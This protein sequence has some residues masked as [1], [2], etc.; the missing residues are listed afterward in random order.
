[1]KKKSLVNCCLIGAG[2]IAKFNASGLKN[3]PEADIIAI[4]D[5]SKSRAGVLSEQFSIPKIYTDIASCLNDTCIDAAVI[6]VPNYLHKEIAVDCL[7]AG[8]HVLL[9]KPFAMNYRQAA[10]IADTAKRNRKILMVGMNQRFLE[11]SQKM[12]YLTQHDQLGDIYAAK[13]YWMRRS[14]CPKFGT[15]FCRKDLAGGGS[16]FDIG[17]HVIDLAM[18]F[19]D[20]F[21]AE[22]VTSKLY[23]RFG[24]RGLGKGTWGMSD[25]GDMIFDV[26]D[27]GVALIKLKHDQH[28]MVESSFAAHMNDC[29]RRGVELFGTEGGAS[30]FPCRFH[31]LGDNEYESVVPTVDTL[32]YPTDRMVHFIDVVLGRTEPMCNVDQSLKLQKVLDAILLSN[33]EER[34]VRITQ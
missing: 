25:S 20:N 27:F 12:K 21:D 4:C 31:H 9:D 8:K 22:S 17:T 10:E 14:G 23:T 28:I 33:Q 2:A 26:D 11:E 6:S 3:H 32:R 5:P 34:E 30:I 13:A 15:W 7:N 19:M 24:N 16:I 1:M 18:Y 29:D